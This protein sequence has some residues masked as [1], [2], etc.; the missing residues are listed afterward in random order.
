VLPTTVV[1][2]PVRNVVTVK[3][4]L[5]F[6]PRLAWTPRVDVMPAGDRLIWQDSENIDRD[7]GWVDTNFGIDNSGNALFLDL[8]GKTALNFAEVT[9]ANGKVQVVDFDART[10]SPGLY[11][12]LDFADGRHIKTVRMLAKSESDATKLTVYLSK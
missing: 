4:P 8:S 10:H 6:L 2:R 1:V 9:F 12:L 3:A 5:V 7:E 11:K